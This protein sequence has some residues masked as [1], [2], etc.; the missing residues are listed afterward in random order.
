MDCANEDGWVYVNPM[1]PYDAI[2]LCGTWC[3][4]LKIIGQADVLYFCDPG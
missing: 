3:G 2:E 4:E 1:G